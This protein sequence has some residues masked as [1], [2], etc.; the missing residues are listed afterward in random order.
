[1]KGLVL[2][3]DWDPR[4]EYTVTPLEEHTRRARHGNM[5]WRNPS[6]AV[7]AR[8]DPVITG[9][10]DVIVLNRVCGICG[11]DVH[12]YIPDQDG[13]L[14][15]P[16]QSRTPIAIGHEYSGEVVEIGSAVTRVK[17]GDLVAVEAQVNCGICRACSRGIP[18]SCEFVEDRGITLDG[19]TATH[20]VAHE[21]Y[22]WPLTDVVEKF[23]ESAALDIGALTEP[24]AVVY[25]GMVG[26]AGGFRP[27]DSVAV[28]GCGPIGLAAVG[29]ATAMGAGRVLA[30]EPSALKRSLSGRLGATAT[31]DPTTGDAREWL[32]DQ[33]DGVGVDM[34]VDASGA[35]TRVMPVIFDSIAVGAKIVCLGVNREPFAMDTVPLMIRAASMYGAIA[36]LGGGYPA[37]IALHAAGRLDLR[38]M[39]T[40][41]YALD[42]ALTA[43]ESAA[44]GTEGKIL[45]HPHGLPG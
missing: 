39:I 9:P 29:L 6:M 2:S 27:G 24:G 41:R 4:P 7:A 11:S 31:F 26:R 15:H 38:A 34:V 1:M 8:P 13:Y 35:A 25:N 21:R 42:D 19:G 40:A 18:S 45:I 44:S 17:V 33:T 16:A 37:I 3:A 28:F 22:C 32:A 20:S 23:G 36:H 10:H 12:M 5:V 30:L 43:M 14:N